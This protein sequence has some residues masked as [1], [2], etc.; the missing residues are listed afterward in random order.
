MQRE[1]LSVTHLEDKIITL[2]P[3]LIKMLYSH[4]VHINE[5]SKQCTI[6]FIA[7]KVAGGIDNCGCRL[8]IRDHASADLLENRPLLLKNYSSQCAEQTSQIIYKSFSFDLISEGENV[9]GITC[10]Y[11]FEDRRV[12]Y[13]YST[14]NTIS[15]KPTI[16][17]FLAQFGKNIQLIHFD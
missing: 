12:P 7:G 1:K 11:Y 14:A 2:S 10:I 3:T 6:D 5:T 9:G 4:Y 16:E 17:F 13:V 8:T 15:N